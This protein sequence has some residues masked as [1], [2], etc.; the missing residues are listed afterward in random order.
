MDPWQSKL[1]SGTCITKTKKENNTTVG[2]YTTI[3]SVM[4]RQQSLCW[5]C[6]LTAWVAE[7]LKVRGRTCCNPES[8]HLNRIRVANSIIIIQAIVWNLACSHCPKLEVF[9]HE[10][11]LVSLRAGPGNLFKDLDNIVKYFNILGHLVQVDL[12]L[13]WVGG[14]LHISLNQ[15]LIPETRSGQFKGC[16][17]YREGLMQEGSQS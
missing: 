7:M 6:S 1:K 11:R 3:H 14:L 5:R 13:S 17:S 16:I 8:I 2:A 12:N 15:S 4:Q 10:N 9:S